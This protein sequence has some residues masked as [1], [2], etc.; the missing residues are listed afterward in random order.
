MNTVT[1]LKRVQM[2]IATLPTGFQFQARDV[3]KC[4]NITT[5]CVGNYLKAMECLTI[6]GKDREGMIYEKIE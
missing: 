5:R 4:T 2:Y 3:A 1:N 6:V